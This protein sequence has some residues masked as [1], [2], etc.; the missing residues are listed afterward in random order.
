[1]TEEQ[2]AEIEEKLGLKLPGKYRRLV[3]EFP[4]ELRDWPL[5]PGETHNQPLTD[6]LLDP[7]QILEAQE[8]ARKRL[9]QDLPDH[10]FVVGRTMGPT[11]EFFWLI[12]TRKKDPPVGRVL[13]GMVLGGL[14][15]LGELLA[16]VRKRHDEAWQVAKAR[17]G[18]GSADLMTPEELLAEAWRMARPAVL[19]K[20][21]GSDYAAVWKGTGVVPPPEGQWEHWISFD[22]RFLPRNP[23]GLRGVISVYLCL[24]DND[25]FETVEAVHDPAAALPEAPDGQR[26]FAEPYDCPP[27]VE[28]LFK[29][30]SPRIQ[31][32]LQAN[33]ASA[34]SHELRDFAPANREAL[35]ALEQM[36]AEKHPFGDRMDCAAMLGGWSAGF[37]WCYGCEEDTPWE[38]LEKPLV[39]LTIRDSEPWLEVIEDGDALLGFSRIT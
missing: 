4:P 19:L 28:A 30:G 25:R 3:G 17:E 37:L 32:W 21:E 5:A 2:L 24:E 13:E 10:S 33:G 11:G 23:R 39:L 34:D 7:A 16:R 31:E 6:F 35:K 27:T 22:P 36:V 15:N 14:K 12:D 29:F 18:A 9:G 1:M 38:I 26:L 20:D 8:A